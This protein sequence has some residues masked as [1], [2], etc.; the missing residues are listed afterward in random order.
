VLL[1]ALSACRSPA[2]WTGLQQENQA[3]R[4]DRSRLERALAKRDATIADLHAQVENLQSF[5]PDRPADLFAPVK[6]EIV[7]LSGGRD[8]DGRPGDDG[9]T[10][11]LRPRDA[12]GDIIKAPGR[13]TI[14]LLDNSD[15]DA[16]RVLGICAV[17]DPDVVRR[18]WYGRFGTNH[19][20][21]DCPFPPDV[22]SLVPRQV[23]VSAE[24][25]DYLTGARLTAVKEVSVSFPDEPDRGEQVP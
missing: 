12:D 20:T 10:V 15:L 25:V 8:Y 4:Q 24:F 19:Y 13:I 2:D 7:S 9:V 14:Q 6:L 1:L 3:L 11:Y 22:L 17:T 23:T 21:I 16:P 18:S 5:D